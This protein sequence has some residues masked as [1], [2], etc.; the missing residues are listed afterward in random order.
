MFWDFVLVLELAGTAAFS[1]AGVFAA[2]KKHMDIFG[3]VFLGCASAVGGGVF[4]D[5]LL[6]VNPPAMFVHPAYVMV[7]MAVSLIVFI[8]LYFDREKTERTTSDYENLINIADSFGLAIFAI[9]GVRAV[10]SEG[11]ADQAFLAVFLGTVTAVG[12]GVFRD[13]LC[14]EV[15]LI[16]TKRIYAVAAILGA[17]TFYYLYVEL[18]VPDMISTAA[19]ISVTVLIRWASIHFHLNLPKL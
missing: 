19:S 13:M 5:I 1:I 18:S 16:L 4:R 6:G 9:S 14:G 12:G 2:K 17:M 15:P 10:I 3:A 8:L 7:A 11:Y